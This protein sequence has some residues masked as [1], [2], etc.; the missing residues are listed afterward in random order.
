MTDQTDG[1]H[2]EPVN[3]G[4]AGGPDGA[5]GFSEPKIPLDLFFE[6]DFVA[7]L[8]TRNIGVVYTMLADHGFTQRQIGALTG[9]AQSE[10]F[11]IMHGRIVQSY[12]TLVRI[13][14][15]LG[16]PRAL[17]GLGYLEFDPTSASIKA[18]EELEALETKLTVYEL[19]RQMG[20]RALVELRE[21]IRAEIT[22]EAM[23]AVGHEL[24]RGRTAASGPLQHQM[25]RWEDAGDGKETAVYLSRWTANEA[26]LLRQALGDTVRSFGKRIGVSDRMISKWDADPDTI[27]R[28]KC[29]AA[30]S[31]CLRRAS[32]DVVARFVFLL[33]KRDEQG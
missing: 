3:D 12:D 24:E 33:I 18:Q 9:Q 30:L 7:A 14:G 8:T 22:N 32:R 31:E 1:E 19:T 10:V 11:E 13:A 27:P 23:V 17:M 2:T 25:V 29:Q 16:V 21:Q 20:E 4:E 26:R 15:G 6:E 28:G 5:S